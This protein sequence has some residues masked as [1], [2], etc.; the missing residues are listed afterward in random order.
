[1]EVLGGQFGLKCSSERNRQHFMAFD[2]SGTGA[3]S[4]SS[5]PVGSAAGSAASLLSL[6]DDIER[7]S[8]E[9]FATMFVS[10]RSAFSTTVL[11]RC[12]SPCPPLPP[13]SPSSA[14]LLSDNGLEHAFSADDARERGTKLMEQL[15]ELRAE[16]ERRT[17]LDLTLNSDD[18]HSALNQSAEASRTIERWR[19][20]ARALS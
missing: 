10:Q 8:E 18:V 15:N 12:L 17:L 2:T 4:A 20:N 5:A 3:S 19:A 16:F 1:M 13:S 7:Q 9:F 14:L 11:T 6:L